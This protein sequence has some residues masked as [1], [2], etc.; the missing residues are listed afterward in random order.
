[1]FIV[2]FSKYFMLIQTQ[3]MLYLFVLNYI[4]ILL[5]KQSS[6]ALHILSPMSAVC[7]L[8]T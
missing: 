1:M 6:L 4:G 5:G 3:A 2:G 7:K 8:H